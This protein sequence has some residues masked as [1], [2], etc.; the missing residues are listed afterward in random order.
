MTTPDIESIRERLEYLRGV[1]RA[2]R[3]SYSELAELQ[4]LADHID[5][6][7]NELLEWAGVP[8]AEAMERQRLIAE[9]RKPAPGTNVSDG[10]E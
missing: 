10:P 6:W 9:A 1:I 3:M 5:P 8:E 7:D 2:E 4:D